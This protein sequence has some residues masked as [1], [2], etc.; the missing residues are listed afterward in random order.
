M[1]TDREWLFFVSVVFGGGFVAGLLV[2]LA[3]VALW[4]CL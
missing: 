1:F 4:R 2:T 3:A